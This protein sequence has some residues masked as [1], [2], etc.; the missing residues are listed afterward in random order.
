L[1]LGEKDVSVGKTRWWRR[2]KK[3]KEPRRIREVSSEKGKRNENLK[4]R[5]LVRQL[6]YSKSGFRRSMSKVIRK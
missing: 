5:N 4:E 6:C 2:R 3:E 1:L